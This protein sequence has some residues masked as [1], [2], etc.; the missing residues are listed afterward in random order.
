MRE[1]TGRRLFARHAAA[2]GACF[3]KVTP[4]PFQAWSRPDLALCTTSATGPVSTLRPLLREMR[5]LDC[6][7]ALD[8]IREAECIQRHA[9]APA[10]RRCGRSR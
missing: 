7:A 1:R 8:L 4:L 5:H 6:E 10:R 2:P 9:C 3:V